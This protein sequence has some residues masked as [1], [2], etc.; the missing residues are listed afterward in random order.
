MVNLLVFLKLTIRNKEYVD[1]AHVKRN[2]RLHH[3]IPFEYSKIS[4]QKHNYKVIF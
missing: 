1:P 4:L 3:T 2:D